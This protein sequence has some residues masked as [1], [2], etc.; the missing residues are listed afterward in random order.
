MSFSSDKRIR[1]KN[2]QLTQCR[3]QRLFVLFLLCRSQQSHP[4][5]VDCTPKGRLIGENA[6][7]NSDSKDCRLL[8]LNYVIMD[9]SV[10]L[11]YRKRGFSSKI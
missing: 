6:S 9:N 3:S 5:G 7:N 10:C 2:Q 11:P 1:L 4:V 8:I